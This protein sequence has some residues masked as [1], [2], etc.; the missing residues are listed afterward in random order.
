MFK[1]TLRALLALTLAALSSFAQFPTVA[2]ASTSGDGYASQVFS[3]MNSRRAAAGLA[4]L[5]WN[6]SIA[7]VSQD[8]ANHLEVVTHSP[9]FDFATIHRPDGGGSLIPAKANWYAEII[10]FNFTAANIVD[11]WMG[12]PAHRDAIL[13]PRA[14]HVGIG[15]VVPTS[16]PYAGFHLVVANL[17][18]Y[19]AGVIPPE[20]PQSFTDIAASGFQS[21][22]LWLRQQGITTGY[23]D[24]SFRPN[25]TVS[26]D[27]MAAFMYRLAKSPSYT[28]PTVS[29]FIDIATN[30]P[31][32]KEIAWMKFAGL[33]TGFPDGSYQS[34]NPVNRDGMAAFMFGFTSGFCHLQSA[35]SF[36]APATATFN[37]SAPGSA[38]FREIAW[39]RANGIT[40]GFPADNTYRGTDMVTREAMA[41]IVHRLSN[42][43]TANGGCR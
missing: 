42:Y 26:R 36:V 27:A 16:G 23:P 10:G 11:W 35:T 21:D 33:S 4:P 5:S 17:A 12:S 22:I 43:V 39:M 41:A 6:Q 9:S 40:T 20:Q 8:W 2:E 15:Y 3:L 13:S 31:Y 32:Y 25:D 38:F 28:P 24:G 1:H 30:S 19:P 18:G 7:N 34:L 29:P 14:T 37:D